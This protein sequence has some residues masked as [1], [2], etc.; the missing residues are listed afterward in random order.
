MVFL[1]NKIGTRGEIKSPV[2]IYHFFFKIFREGEYLRNGNKKY[3]CGCEVVTGSSQ[4]GIL[5]R[6]E[7]LRKRGLYRARE[8]H[9]SVHSDSFGDY[10]VDCQIQ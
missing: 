2:N 6:C 10:R 7:L 3:I 4:L 1:V 9:V 5:S 8:C